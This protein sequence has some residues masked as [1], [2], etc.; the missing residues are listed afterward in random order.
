MTERQALLLGHAHGDELPAA[1]HQDLQERLF[2]RRQGTDETLPFRMPGQDLGEFGQSLGVDAV[3]LG[4]IP[5]PWR[6]PAPGGD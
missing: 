4:E 2:W 3:G 5:W 6:N 1:G